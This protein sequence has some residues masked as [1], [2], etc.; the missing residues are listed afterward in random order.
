[1]P[2]FDLR[3]AWADLLRRRPAFA[4]ALALY[5]GLVD[6]WAATDVEVP[7]LAWP[8]AES[9]SRWARGVPLLA[10][11]P[12]SLAPDEVE[13]SLSRAIEAIVAVRPDTA[14]GLQRFAEGWDAGA[15]TPAS[16]LPAPGRVGTLADAVGDD[17]AAHLAV[18]VLRPRL[19][20]YLAACR[21]HLTDGDWTLGICPFCGAPP[22]YADVIEDGRRRLTCHVCG[23]AWI[24]PRFRCPFCGEEETK[25]LGRLDFE[26]R[27]DQGY[28][29]STCTGCRGYLKEIDRRVRWNGGPA[30]LEDWGSP[31]V[32][33]ACSRAGF[34]RPLAPVI[35]AGRNS[36]R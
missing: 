10:E 34:T 11:A 2:R 31:H 18:A 14:E 1:M 21:D 32:D 6:D 26:E 15:I 12:P 7:P 30:L 22:G 33:V 24:F 23:G 36:G 3:D 20:P 19:E 28:F 17:V 4:D 35:L 16:L 8:E 27:T 13:E 25:H 9:R 5:G 29:V